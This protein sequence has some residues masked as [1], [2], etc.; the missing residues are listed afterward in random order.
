MDLQAKRAEAERQLEAL[1]NQEASLREQVEQIS[2]LKHQVIG[3]IKLLNELLQ[4]EDTN[5]KLP[6]DDAVEAVAEANGE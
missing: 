2:G 3:Q 6:D 4:S 1:A 5:G